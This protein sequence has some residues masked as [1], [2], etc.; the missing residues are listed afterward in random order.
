VP[1][2]ALDYALPW[3]MTQ[4]KAR[5]NV[6]DLFAAVDM[7]PTEALACLAAATHA[8]ALF[9]PHGKQRLGHL[10]PV[11]A[12][13]RVRVHLYNHSDTV[14]PFRGV[15]SSLLGVCPPSPALPPPP[16]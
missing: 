11:L 5:V 2:G 13:S 16:R 10:Q 6:P 3:D 12:E 14:Q 4:V 9:S 7:A 8:V 1:D 15:R